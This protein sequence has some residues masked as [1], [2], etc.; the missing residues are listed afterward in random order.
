MRLFPGSA[1]S[2]SAACTT[3]A[4]PCGPPSACASAPC[5]G[6]PAPTACGTLSRRPTLNSSRRGVPA[7]QPLGAAAAA[8]CVGG[9]VGLGWTG[10]DRCSSGA[11]AE[12]CCS[13]APPLLQRPT[14][15]MQRNRITTPHQRLLNST[16]TRAPEVV[17]IAE[18]QADA[19]NSVCCA[20]RRRGLPQSLLR[21]QHLGG[22]TGFWV[23]YSCLY[24]GVDAR[25]GSFKGPFHFYL[26]W[27]G[28]SLMCRLR[29]LIV[30]RSKNGMLVPV[31]CKP[32]KLVREDGIL[33]PSDKKPL[34]KARS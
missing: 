10:V 26:I 9:W 16:N 25:K 11:R 2:A 27:W 8:F 15:C 34:L 21:R 32:L 4:R 30:V 13:A 1:A 23:R 7:H 29:D 14:A 24:G 17:S 12:A 28:V 31:A 6:A 5:R 22:L 18:R 3:N 19:R 20:D 33:S